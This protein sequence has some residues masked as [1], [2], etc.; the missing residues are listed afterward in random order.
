[1]TY[2]AD[3]GSFSFSA[4]PAGEVTLQVTYTGYETASTRLTIGSGRTATHQFDLK[5]AVYQPES[6]AAPGAP[7]VLLESFTVSSEREGN[8]PQ[9]DRK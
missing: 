6:K 9:P 8:A 1:M 2:S 7:V 5:G 4:V 3:D